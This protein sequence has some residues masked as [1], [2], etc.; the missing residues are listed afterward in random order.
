MVLAYMS[1]SQ[2]RG[3]R[4]LEAFP[5]RRGIDEGV[6]EI[7]ISAEQLLVQKGGILYVAIEREVYRVRSRNVLDGY[8]FDRHGDEM[9]VFA[10]RRPDADLTILLQAQVKR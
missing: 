5:Y 1:R 2:G 9:A 8:G 3:K 6:F 7:G 4:S 10:M